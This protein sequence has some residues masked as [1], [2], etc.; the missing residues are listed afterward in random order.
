MKE[1]KLVPHHEH[2][3]YWYVL[4]LVLALVLSTKLWRL[5]KLDDNFPP[6]WAEE[7]V[8]LQY[9]WNCQS[10]SNPTHCITPSIISRECTTFLWQPGKTKAK[11][12]ALVLCVALSFCQWTVYCT[13]GACGGIAIAL[14]C[15][16]TISCASAHQLQKLQINNMAL[17]F[18]SSKLWKCEE[19]KVYP[20]LV[21]LRWK[22]KMEAN[23]LKI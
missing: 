21:W 20:N 4:V 15:T 8:Q 1:V 16:L 5:T 3:E 7:K 6:P 2:F 14:Y 23:W 9:S 13:P 18:F 22:Q 12:T 17:V 10:L 19:D 11:G